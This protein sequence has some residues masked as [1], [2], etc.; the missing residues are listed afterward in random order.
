MLTVP[1]IALSHCTNLNPATFLPS[2]T[3]ETPHHCLTLTG[4][5]L[6]PC[7][8]LEETPLTNAD[9]SWFTDGSYLKGESGKYCAEYAI[10][11]PFDIFEATPLPMA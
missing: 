8:N 3:D 6:T 4:H 1:H 2:F 11:T 5:P 10:A 9:F 7:N